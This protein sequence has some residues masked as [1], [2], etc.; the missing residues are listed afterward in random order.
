LKLEVGPDQIVRQAGQT[1]FAGSALRPIDGIFRA[2]AMLDVPWRELWR[3]M[4]DRPARFMGLSHEWAVGRPAT[5][6]LL[7]ENTG[8]GLA[9]LRFFARGRECLSC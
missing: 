4:S 1:N 2:A 5:F 9:D 7:T 8:R 3:R 6:C